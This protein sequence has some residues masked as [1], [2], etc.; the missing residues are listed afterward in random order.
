MINDMEALSN[1]SEKRNNLK[2]INNKEVLDKF[3]VL[4]NRHAKALSHSV[5]FCLS[6]LSLMAI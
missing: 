1:D 6:V 5:P 4:S 3:L 2:L